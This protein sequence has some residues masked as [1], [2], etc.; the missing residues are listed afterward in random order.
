MVGSIPAK[1]EEDGGEGVER[2]EK[3]ETGEDGGREQPGGREAVSK[4]KGSGCAHKAV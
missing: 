2:A 4:V 3:A 1:D